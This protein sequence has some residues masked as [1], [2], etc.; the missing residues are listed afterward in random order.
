M[1]TVQI[2]YAANIYVN[3][4]E[5]SFE[6]TSII[7]NDRTMVPLRGVA[8]GMGLFVQWKGEEKSAIMYNDNVEV[9]FSVGDNY[10]YK[11]GLGKYFDTAPMM[12]GSYVYVPV[13]PLAEAV[14]GEV[15][16]DGEN[17]WIDIDAV[18]DMTDW[19]RRI[20]ELINNERTSRGIEPLVWNDDLAHTAR[21]K[22]N[23]MMENGYFEHN[24]P[25]GI[26][27]FDIMHSNGIVYKAAAENIA[28]GQAS[29]ETAVAAWME[30]DEHR[31]AI[32]NPVYKETGIGIA[33]GGIYGI[34]WTQ[35]FAF[36]R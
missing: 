34:Y 12:M 24:S 8:E 3:G 33:V 7:Y 27:P 16:W 4:T 9:M 21:I 14:G 15:Y 30:S 1:L 28:A 2:S 25:D 22:S 23:D 10:I 11:N 32:L 26:S 20:L 5:V 13:R 17:V 35:H 36:L 19:D 18:T 31:E 6:Q 29:P